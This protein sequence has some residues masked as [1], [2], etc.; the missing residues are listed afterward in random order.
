MRGTSQLDVTLIALLDSLN[1]PTDHEVSVAIAVSLLF[2]CLRS[3][4][5]FEVDRLSDP[6][7]P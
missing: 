3:L 1:P 2:A 7:R 4:L 6:D 5:T